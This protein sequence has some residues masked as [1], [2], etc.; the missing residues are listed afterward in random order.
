MRVA[1]VS[2]NREKLPDAVIPMGVLLLAGGLPSR[3][4]RILIDL[5][6]EDEPLDVLTSRLADFRPDLIALGMRNIQRADYSGTAD[7]IAYYEEL[8]R[9]IRKTSAAPVV[10]GGSGFSIIPAE[11][12]ERLRPDYGISGEAESAFPA[13]VQAIE[14]GATGFD[15]IGNLHRFVGDDLIS[16]PPPPSFLDM[17]QLPTADRS[18][19]DPRYYAQYGIDAVQTKRGCPLRCEYCTYPVIEGRVGRTRAPEIVVDELEFIIETQPDLKHVFIVDSVFN[20]PRAHAKAVCRE[21]IDRKLSIPWTCYVNPLGFD[22][23]LAELMAAAGC[24][25]MEVGTDSGVDRMLKLLNKGFTTEHVRSLSKLAG[26]AG[27]PDCHTFLLGTPGETV[28]DVLQTLDF[29]IDLDPAGA[30][31]MAWIDEHESLDPVLAKQRI[32]LRDTVY[33]LLDER[34]NEYPWWSIPS[35]GFNYDPAL[36][37]QLRKQGYHGPLWQHM[38]KLMTPAVRRRKRRAQ[39]GDQPGTR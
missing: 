9:T 21:M 34:K 2:G 36:F 8:I 6:F 29:V 23:E 26:D 28:D 37:D 4:E 5:C 22:A 20:L 31:L 16:N 35:I 14:A 10:M 18:L 25:G 27:I 30:I 24:A 13:L 39:D 32:A 17:D 19:L 12:M 3:H 38:R 15:E 1:F 7:T 33:E 11:L